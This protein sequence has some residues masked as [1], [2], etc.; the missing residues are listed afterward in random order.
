MEYRGAFFLQAGGMILNDVM[1]LFFWVIFY[2]N[3]PSLNGWTMRDVLILYALV[4]GAF[5]LVNVVFGNSFEIAR[6]IVSG[7]LDY[8]LVLPADPLLH[9]LVS[10]SSMSAWGDLVFGIGLATWLFWGEWPLLILFL[11]VM[12]IATLVFLA[13]T[14]L[15]GS[16]AFFIGQSET[17]SRQLI[18]A[19]ITFGTYPV[20]IFPLVIKVVLFTLI[21]AAFIS[22]VPARLLTGFDAGRAALFLLATAGFLA[23]ALIV[24]RR[25]LRRYASGNL[26]VTRL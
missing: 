12:S 1:L 17:L 22:S 24:F 23:L 10:R 19:L 13:F 2:A 8:Y 18:N 14:I 25:G 21:P 6:I 5:G 16:L 9:L 3:V 7:G 11:L 4:A 26:M 15:A 20:D